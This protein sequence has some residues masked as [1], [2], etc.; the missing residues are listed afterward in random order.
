MVKL[1]VSAMEI[2][3]WSEEKQEVKL[4]QDILEGTH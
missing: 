4:G 3:S 1:E 2:S